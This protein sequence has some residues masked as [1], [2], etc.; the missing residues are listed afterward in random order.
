MQGY[1]LGYLRS[2]IG[3]LLVIVFL[4]TG[5]SSV[6]NNNLEGDV[7]NFSED[8]SNA[9]RYHVTSNFLD[10]EAVNTYPQKI[11][12]INSE[13]PYDIILLVEN[14]HYFKLEPVPYERYS[15]DDKIAP[16]LESTEKIQTGTE[17]VSEIAQS[18]ITEGVSVQEVVSKAL[19][20][21]K[22]NI[23]YDKALQHILFYNLSKSRSAEETLKLGKGTCLEYANTFIAFMRNLGIP[24]RLVFGFYKDGD[25]SVYHAWAEFYL[26]GHGWI[27]AETQTGKIGIPNSLVKLFVGRDITDIDLKLYQCNAHYEILE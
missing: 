6:A 22:D 10:L 11:E 21:N 25:I 12:K 16:Y 4:I 24:A 7:E 14:K 20:Y 27:P 2:K 13:E 5:C 17:L 18:F 26:K 23:V 9:V 1:L 3:V 8:Y 15:Y 19:L